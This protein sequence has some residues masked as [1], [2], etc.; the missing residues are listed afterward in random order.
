[1]NPVIFS[2]G[3]FEI[4]WY[5]ALILIGFFVATYLIE[6]E[7]KRFDIDKNFIFNLLFWTLIMGIIGARIYYVI[8]CI[9]VV[10]YD[11]HTC[12]FE[13]FSH[14]FSFVLVDLATQCIKSRFHVSSR[15]CP[16]TLKYYYTILLFCL[17]PAKCKNP[18]KAQ[19][20]SGNCKAYGGKCRGRS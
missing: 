16:Y 10:R 6:K 5:S 20:D 8:V 18:H 2:I 3:K 9:L 11:L 17:Q 7:A 14:I 4:R 19:S 1:M 13:D 12:I 15:F